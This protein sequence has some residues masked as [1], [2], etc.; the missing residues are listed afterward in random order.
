MADLIALNRRR[1]PQRGMFFSKSELSQLLSVYSA[2]VISG[3]WRDYAID[4]RD[5]MAVFSIFRRSDE[6]PLFAIAKMLQKGQAKPAFV[7]FN[8]PRKVATSASL[9]EIVQRFNRQ[10]RLVSG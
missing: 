9:M 1:L 4:Q 3:E 2:R 10:P 5:E 8:G 7:L 6:Q